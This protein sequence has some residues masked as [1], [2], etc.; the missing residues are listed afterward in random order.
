MEE[1]SEESPAQA[2]ETVAESLEEAKSELTAFAEGKPRQPLLAA[3]FSNRVREQH[4]QADSA[5]GR[6][7]RAR[8]T[9][10]N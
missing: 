10:R 3:E 5:E 8:F 7:H 2:L 4:Q 9:T 1:G 6:A